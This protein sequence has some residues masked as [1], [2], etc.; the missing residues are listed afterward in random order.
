MKPKQA[1]S[2]Y[3]LKKYGKKHAHRKYKVEAE[4][5]FAPFPETQPQLPKRPGSSLGVSSLGKGPDSVS[6]EG[7]VCFRI[8]LTTCDRPERLG[9][10]LEDLIRESEWAGAVE[11]IVADDGREPIGEDLKAIIA[12]AG[13]RYLRSRRQFGKEGYGKLLHGALQGEYRAWQGGEY[14]MGTLWMVMQDDFRL[15]A[16]FFPRL[17]EAWREGRRYG[18]VALQYHIDQSRRNWKGPLGESVDEVNWLDACTVASRIFWGRLKWTIHGHRAKE[19]NSSGVGNWLTARLLYDFPDGIA[20]RTK[21]SLVVHARD[22]SLMN[23]DVDR[24]PDAMRTA[25]FIDGD[26]ARDRLEQ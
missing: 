26:E 8:I 5:E 15:C 16:Q 6:R 13:W 20:V 25:R 3:I 22:R 11:L 12:S 9:R 24:K 7:P 18:A 17:V 14:R 19:G 2:R 10:L 23:P 21:E 1:I 4:D